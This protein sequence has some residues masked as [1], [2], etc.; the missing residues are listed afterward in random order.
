MPAAGLPLFEA[1]NREPIHR[2]VEWDTA[3]IVIRG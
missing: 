1:G 3:E 2:L